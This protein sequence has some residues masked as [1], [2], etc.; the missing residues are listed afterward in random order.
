MLPE[1]RRY[2]ALLLPA[3]LAALAA[4]PAAPSEPPSA[5]QPSPNASILPAP[6]GRATVPPTTL[7]ASTTSDGGADAT[8]PPPVVL[9]EDEPLPGEADAELAPHGVSLTARF[10]WPEVVPPPPSP[11]ADPRALAAAA[12]AVART[13]SIEL[14]TTGRMRLRLESGTF[15]LAVG[16]E[17]RAR[18]SLHGHVLVWP[19]GVSYRILQP[20]TLRA[21][22][23]EGRADVGPLA[24]AGV[25]EQPPGSRLGFSTRV[26]EV[27]TPAGKALVQQATMPHGEGGELLCRTLLELVAA[28][29][30]T[31]ICDPAYVPLW[32]DYTFAAGGRLTFEVTSVEPTETLPADHFRL[33]PRE[34]SF[35]ADRVPRA[36]GDVLLDGAA[37]RTLR[38]RDAPT[39]TAAPGAPLEGLVAENPEDTIRYLIVDGIPIARLP[40]RSTRVLTG[41][42]P[43]RYTIT[44]TDFF[45][46]ALQPPRVEPVP[47]RF[48]VGGDGDAGV[49]GP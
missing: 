24:L 41:L 15:A 37:L 35:K 42:R 8:R 29:P 33:P 46:G 13:L 2:L 40:P 21:L 7:D 25:K 47:T 22:F 10:T 12:T 30:A 34:N 5:V 38:R 36:A 26:S 27:I 28:R 3:G 18:A 16:T 43:G 1:R 14:S 44:S 32:V 11:E 23:D 39:D 17:L 20:G 49:P 45:G 4:C 48:L 31:D 19:D 6:L 9:R